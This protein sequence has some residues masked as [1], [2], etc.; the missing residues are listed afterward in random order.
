M[1]GY[2]SFMN[3]T[4]KF[5]GKYNSLYKELSKD[6]DISN[7][8]IKYLNEDIDLNN[9]TYTIIE[10]VGYKNSNGT[11]WACPKDQ[12]ITHENI[13]PF[14]GY[15]GAVW[16]IITKPEYEIRYR[17]GENILLTLIQY[18]LPEMVKIFIK[19]HIM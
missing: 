3:P 19:F 10:I 17:H 1:L 6:I 16:K 7:L 5:V 13:I 9:I 8:E 4:P 18:I 12:E 15:L 14:T 2:P 11:L